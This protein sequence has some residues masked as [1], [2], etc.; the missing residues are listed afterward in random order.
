[1]HFCSVCQNMY[2]IKINDRG[3]LAYYCRNCGNDQTDFN[4]SIVTVSELIVD[5]Q[6]TQSYAHLIN[7]YTKYDPT[8]PR[9]NT[10]PCPNSA[11]TEKHDK[12]GTK[13]EIVYVR[14][15]SVNLKYVYICC[16]CDTVWTP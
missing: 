6:Q 1:M 14:Y 7:Q 8:L 3:E 16:D 13:P 4:G 11:C 9:T 12:A 2:Y 15:D 10:M 5:Q